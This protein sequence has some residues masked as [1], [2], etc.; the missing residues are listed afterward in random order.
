MRIYMN[1]SS[2]DSKRMKGDFIA[3]FLGFFFFLMVLSLPV[4]AQESPFLPSPEATAAPAELTDIL[5]D[6][7]QEAPSSVDPSSEEGTGSLDIPMIILEGMGPP[8]SPMI[9]FE[10]AGSTDGPLITLDG[11]GS[12][13]TAAVNEPV[14]DS[15][16]VYTEDELIAWLTHNST[17]TVSLGANITITRNIAVVA[18]VTIDTGVY[19]LIFDKAFVTN[20]DPGRFI[21][22]GVD[23]P[24][25]SIE[26]TL[27]VRGGDWNNILRKL[28]IT[29]TGRNGEG[30]T[31]LR[32]L[33]QNQGAL[34][35]SSIFSTEPGKIH[36]SGAGAIG[37]ELAVPFDL[38]GFDVEA[39]GDGSIAIY[40]DGGGSAQFCKLSADSA[41]V[42]SESAGFI[43]HHCAASPVV[44]QE[45]VL[46]T[47]AEFS[48][49]PDYRPV[50]LNG[51][52]SDITAISAVPFKETAA[53]SKISSYYVQWDQDA[54]NRIDTSKTGASI[55][56]GEIL[57]EYVTD[58]FSSLFS[59]D[60]TASL[61]IDVR[62]PGIPC[63]QVVRFYERSSDDELVA[64]MLIMWRLPPEDWE[65]CVLWRS[66]DGGKTWYDCTA[67]PEVTWINNIGTS[68]SVD[69]EVAIISEGTMFQVESPGVGESNIVFFTFADGDPD[70][71]QGGD[72]H[73]YDRVIGA[74]PGTVIP[75]P[76]LDPDNDGDG[77]GDGSGVG[78][79]DQN[80]PPPGDDGDGENGDNGD[81]GDI[82]D[83]ETNSQP[84]N[85]G[86]S[87]NTNPN[88]ETGDT[89]N[90]NPSSGDSGDDNGEQNV[91]LP[92]N[93]E[94][95]YHNNNRNNN[96]AVAARINPHPIN[97]VLVNNTQRHEPDNNDPA[98][99]NNGNNSNGTGDNKN[100]SPSPDNRSSNP[101]G[102]DGSSLSP[103]NPSA[104][105]NPNAIIEEL[106]VPIDRLQPAQAAIANISRDTSA[107]VAALNIQ[108][109][110]VP[111]APILE[112]SPK[113]ANIQ[114]VQDIDMRS[115]ARDIPDIPDAPVPGSPIS[116]DAVERANLP[117]APGDTVIAAGSLPQEI[118]E[119]I[120]TP[121]SN[122]ARSDPSNPILPVALGG[123][124][125]VCG[126]AAAY[127]LKRRRLIR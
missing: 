84:P 4:Y 41:V 14:V 62:D 27:F 126:G 55:V 97:G 87:G 42:Y 81:N 119:K 63:I 2:D 70:T 69:I 12:P 23:I 22:E 78:D 39:V 127:I 82:E 113:Q 46:V 15:D 99:G 67:D 7:S 51:D 35:A 31:A 118:L 110:P 95:E 120:D 85:D 58:W 74:K 94:N 90:N 49:Y 86:G 91:P 83:N 66:D 53:Y 75:D 5:I 24:V 88:H 96:P 1:R 6:Q 9:T 68:Q 102:S 103:V 17:G 11:T 79:D 21:G 37:V 61:M 107:N 73:G 124:A 48:D 64:S 101:S 76:D 77:S 106:V 19:G 108:G 116:G 38:Y 122:S 89:G 117:D 125:V 32:I 93:G 112:A 34:N 65:Q 57:L 98:S 16:T 121:A 20:S 8:D 104:D 71:G 45:G 100:S 109:T 92:G 72:R 3:L 111:G 43:I 18:P 52:L 26:E 114:D 40:T 47:W 50:A 25:V 80:N 56:S 29:A 30:G 60:M 10:D 36:S 28:N 44:S 105:E 123:G 13:E 115:A 33:S 54:L 59:A